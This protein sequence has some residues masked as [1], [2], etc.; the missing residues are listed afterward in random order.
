M[1]G[2]AKSKRG[3][4][5][6]HHLFKLPTMTDAVTHKDLTDDKLETTQPPAAQE[7]LGNALTRYIVNK[8]EKLR[9]NPVYKILFFAQSAHMIMALAVVLVTVLVFPSESKMSS[10]QA[11]RI[12]LSKL[13]NIVHLAAF[14]THFGIHIWMTFISGVCLY[15]KLSRHAFGDVQKILFP[16]Y[17]STSSLLNAITLIQFS[18]ICVAN[19]VWDIHTF[20][21]LYV[22]SLCFLM[23]L[24]IRL[25]VVP[26][27]LRL[28]SAKTAIE[29]SAGIGNEVGRQDLGPLV[30]C[31]H[32]MAIHRTFRK[33]HMVMAVCNI[34]TMM[35]NVFHLVYIAT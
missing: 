1:S 32:Y 2:T 21:Q 31:P 6:P 16:K 11:E 9:E 7:E 26:P 34:I 13:V 10:R 24:G 30:N 33:V 22:M 3:Y 18:K 23:E 29:K 4:G 27:M 5:H 25:Y 20:L 15:Y 12:K 14:S 8:C 28:I 35:C 19:N 17:Y